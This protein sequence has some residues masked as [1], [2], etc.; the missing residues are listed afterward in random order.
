MPD[1]VILSLELVFKLRNEA[2]F[3]Q[4]L[5]SISNPSSPNYRHF[6]NA[7]TLEPYVPTPGQKESVMNFLEKQGFTVTVG[8][9]PLVLQLTGTVGTIRRAF[10]TRLSLYMQASNAF[11]SPDSDPNMPQNLG[12]LVTAIAGLENF[13]VIRPAEFP[14]GSSGYP[15][16]PKGIQVGYT[17]SYIYSSGRDGT[18]E[19]VAVVDMPGDPN[20]QIAMNRYTG[21]Y[22]YALPSTVLSIKYPEGTPPSSYDSTWAAESAMDVEA[23]HSVAPGAKIVLLYNSNA[24][25]DLMDAVDYVANQGLAQIVSNS[26]GYA[27]ASGPCSDTQLT[28]SLVSSVDSR[29][30]V[31]SALGLTILFASGDQAAKPDGSNLGTEFPASDP[32]VLAVGA[33]DLTLVGCGP[34]TC[35]AYGSESGASISGGGYSGYFSEP[36]W[37]TSAIGTKL[38]RAVP[39]V[40][41][42][43]YS[44]SFWVYSTLANACGG[45]SGGGWF[46]CSGTSLSTPLWAGFLALALQVRG[47]GYLGNVAPLLYQL[48]LTSSYSFDFHDITTGSNGY[49]AGTGWDPVTGLGTPI[50]GRL[51]LDLSPVLVST[52]KATYTHGTDFLDFTGSGLT[53]G[54][55]VYA[56]ISIDND[57]TV[58]QVGPYYADTYG[59][60]DG[61]ILV[62]SDIPAGPQKFFIKDDSTGRFSNQ[63]QLTILGTPT[64][65]TLS[66]APSSISLG[67]STVLSGSIIPNAGSVQLAISAS[68]DSGLTW[69]TLML[70]MTD[71]SG[72]YST[73]WIPP[74]SGSYLLESSWSGNNWYAGSSSSPASLTVA[75]TA[76]QNPTLL[77]SAPATVSRN[78]LIRLSTTVFNPTAAPMLAD[79]TIQ[80]TGPGSYFIF[81]VVQ[82]NV[83]G[84][85]QSTGYY[86]WTV[87][88]QS[89]TYTVTIGLLPPKPSAFDTLSIQVS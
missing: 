20:I 58:V 46:G 44:P 61:S 29:L 86:D 24:D 79:V 31:D 2:A 50:A 33:T 83:A 69:T 38:G 25:P 76:V 59:Y 74:Y 36:S 10:G 35:S 54:G 42:L 73:S 28:P 8:S 30:A 53:V 81:D 11:Y 43:G 65:I 1:S 15:D 72:D 77:L 22:S 78:Q 82:V 26:W 75:S 55:A 70:I 6:L 45:G 16:C 17:F 56:Y 87:P 13:T 57:G 27:C 49:S 71:S 32:N 64:A 48:A 5:T 12:T 63:V 37:Q 62:K 7:D 40:S 60:V 41:I 34:I 66:L 18:G 47:G 89:G 85:S 68:K 3:D 80:I 51:A 84:N 67:S 88:N 52:D 4:C 39:D 19:T 21:N 14:C 23:V 9:S